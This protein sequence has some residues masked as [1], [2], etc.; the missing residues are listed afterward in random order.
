MISILSL[1]EAKILPSL[2]P[3]DVNNVVDRVTKKT[4]ERLA[5]RRG[6]V[7]MYGKEKLLGMTPLGSK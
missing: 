1:I 5:K 3:K 6:T 2:E 7:L 4:E